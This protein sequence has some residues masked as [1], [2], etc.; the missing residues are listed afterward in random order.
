M[1]HVNN[2]E[3]FCRY[4]YEISAGKSR[5]P[6]WIFAD[7]EWHEVKEYHRARGSLRTWINSAEIAAGG[8]LD[9]RPGDVLLVDIFDLLNNGVAHAGS[10][11]H[12]QMVHSYDPATGTAFFI[13]GNASFLVARRPGEAAPRGESHSAR[14]ERERSEKALGTPLKPGG[15]VGHVGVGAYDLRRQPNP[16]DFEDF[17]YGPKSSEPW[18]KDVGDP[19]AP[20]SRRVYGIG[21]PSLVDME[22]HTYASTAAKPTKKP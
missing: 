16:Y 15:A 20:R 1:F 10:P 7:G 22:S 5:V 19:T 12:I 9:V 11:D 2:V 6:K 4:Q 3:H 17:N 18:R 8:Q 21:R 13:D 14:K